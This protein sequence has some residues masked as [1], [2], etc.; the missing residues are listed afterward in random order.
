MKVIKKE[1][2]RKKISKKEVKGVRKVERKR[3]Q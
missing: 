2:L 1:K 3:N